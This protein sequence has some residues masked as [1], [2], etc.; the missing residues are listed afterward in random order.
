[1]GR[2]V[3]V[4]ASQP[5]QMVAQH[6]EMHRLLGRHP[7]PIPMEI[8][9]QAG[10]AID[11]VQG[12][13]DGGELDVG[14]GVDQ[15]RMAVRLVQLPARHGLGRRQFGAVRAARFQHRFRVPPIHRREPARPPV[16]Q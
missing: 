12:Q 10:E 8:P 2:E 13:V 7:Q 1:V 3:A 15:G 9:R 4:V 6:A 11:R 16:V 14:Q 5:A